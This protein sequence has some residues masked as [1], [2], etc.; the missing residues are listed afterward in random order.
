VQR[1]FGN[2]DTIYSMTIDL[3]QALDHE[4]LQYQTDAKSAIS[5][6]PFL[7]THEQRLSATPDYYFRQDSLSSTSDSTPDGP[8]DANDIGIAQYQCSPLQNIGLIMSTAVCPSYLMKLVS[9]T[10]SLTHSLSL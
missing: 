6:R 1:I 7:S 10:H 8:V 3:F 4:W 9:L 2:I 5:E